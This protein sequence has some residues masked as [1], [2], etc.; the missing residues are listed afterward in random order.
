MRLFCISD[1]DYGDFIRKD[2]TENTFTDETHSS[3]W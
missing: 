2:G 3:A 1:G